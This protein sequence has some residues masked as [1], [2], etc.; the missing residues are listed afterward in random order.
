MIVKC[1]GT[2]RCRGREMDRNV[3]AHPFFVVNL[4]WAIWAGRCM[5]YIGFNEILH[6]RINDLVHASESIPPTGRT[7]SE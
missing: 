3:L 5:R 7:T 4:F 1:M 6:F 2:K